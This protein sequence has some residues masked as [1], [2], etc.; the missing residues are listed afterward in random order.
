MI[1]APLKSSPLC[2]T[3]SY[4]SSS[5][6]LA[7]PLPHIPARCRCSLLP[8]RDNCYTLRVPLLLPARPSLRLS[9]WGHCCMP[10]H[11]VKRPR[12]WFSACPR[13]PLPLYPC[14]K[15]VEEHTDHRDL[16]RCLLSLSKRAT[17]ILDKTSNTARDSI[18]FLH[19]FFLCEVEAL[20]SELLFIQMIIP[21]ISIW[22]G[23]HEYYFY[24]T[25][26][27]S[28]GRDMN[29]FIII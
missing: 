14:R 24:H 28:V 18:V 7:L 8:L 22:Y 1:H 29:P 12:R 15:H 13:W 11:G 3:S 17:Q 9:P 16:S 5:R 26:D 19:A 6:T 20:L 2:E 23:S 27:E 21:F 25:A 10:V 4:H